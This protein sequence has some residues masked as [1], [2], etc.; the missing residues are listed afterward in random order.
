LIFNHFH[1]RWEITEILRNQPTVAFW[2]YVVGKYT[3]GDFR[4]SIV[5]GEVRHLFKTQLPAA[6]RRAR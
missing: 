1:N 2:H 3:N 5:H 4:E 6:Q